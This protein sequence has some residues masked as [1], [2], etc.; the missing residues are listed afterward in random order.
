MTNRLIEMALVLFIRS[1]NRNASN[2]ARAESFEHTA[3]IHAD[4]QAGQCVP[5]VCL[6]RHAA[7]SYGER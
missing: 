4:H 3:P 7:G 6:P 2:G 5:C 1:L